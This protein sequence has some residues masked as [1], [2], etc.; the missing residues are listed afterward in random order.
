MIT[1][2]II[3]KAELI[4][5][6]VLVVLLA[7][8]GLSGHSF[9]KSQDLTAKIKAM[10][11]DELFSCFDTLK[12]SYEEKATYWKGQELSGILEER[13]QRR[14]FERLSDGEFMVLYNKARTRYERKSTYWN[15]REIAYYND[16]L[17]KRNWKGRQI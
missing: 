17:K 11:D 2:V 15:E 12:K 16:E 14:L 6:L 5:A 8:Y 3:T 10:S 4:A 13:K 9:R 1:I 7:M